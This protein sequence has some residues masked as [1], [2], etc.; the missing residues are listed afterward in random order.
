MDL[1]VVPLDDHSLIL[2]QEFLHLAKEVPVPHARRLVFLG[3]D[4]R[5][6]LPM[7]QKIKLGYR[8]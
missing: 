6:S 7:T 2:G 8:P 3:E 4:G 1:K 5:W